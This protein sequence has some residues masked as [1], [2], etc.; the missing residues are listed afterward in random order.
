MK[1][2]GGEGERRC[3]FLSRRQTR[4]PAPL[5]LPN[6]VF[7]RPPRPTAHSLSPPHTT[8]TSIQCCHQPHQRPA[9]THTQHTMAAPG[10]GKVSS[11]LQH[12]LVQEQAKA[13]VW[14]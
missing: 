7:V 4:R 9:R 11:E 13:Q 14:L 1:T 8:L 5:H 3:F 10:D 12:F 6:F 2:S